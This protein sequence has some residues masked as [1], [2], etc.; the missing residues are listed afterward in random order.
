MALTHLTQASKKP[1]PVEKPV[2]RG[3]HKRV[4]T[5]QANFPLD[6]RL[7]IYQNLSMSKQG[8]PMP[9]A[10]LYLLLALLG[11]ENHGYALM[12]LVEEQ[13]NAA[14]QMGPGTL[15]G[16]LNR[17]LDSGLIVE[18]TEQRDPDANERRRYYQL[19]AQGSR[20]AVTELQRLRNLV[21]R[22]HSIGGLEGIGT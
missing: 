7:P 16:T 17:L 10:S 22:F 15:Y 2:P 9:A 20:V 13:S 18:T 6:Y 14:V 11:G 12:K 1:K 19:T 3:T 5:R 21:S 8:K 4:T